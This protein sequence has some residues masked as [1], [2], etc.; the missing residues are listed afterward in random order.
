MLRNEVL[1]VQAATQALLL[2]EATLIDNHLCSDNP[3]RVNGWY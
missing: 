1:Q 3:E 2:G